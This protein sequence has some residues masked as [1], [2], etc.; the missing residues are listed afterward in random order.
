M[1]MV[2]LEY[3]LCPRVYCWEVAVQSYS[4]NTVEPFGNGALLE[5]LCQE[6]LIIKWIHAVSQK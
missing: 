5:L 2:L 6:D 3:D 1:H 4:A